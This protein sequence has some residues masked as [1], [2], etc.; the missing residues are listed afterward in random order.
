[1]KTFQA[2][3]LPAVQLPAVQRPAAG[4]LH[5]KWNPVVARS[6]HLSGTAASLS[7][8][9]SLTST[10]GPKILSNPVTTN[11][12]VEN[13]VIWQLPNLLVGFTSYSAATAFF[14]SVKS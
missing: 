3:Q 4:A 9:G 6:V 11:L 8:L 1:M 14:S 12:W 2:S 13:G 10:H 5:A 7:R